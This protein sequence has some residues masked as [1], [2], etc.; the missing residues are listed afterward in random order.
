MKSENE[1]KAL[2]LEELQKFVIELRAVTTGD[3]FY[4]TA[5]VLLAFATGLKKYKEPELVEVT[6]EADH[7]V[8]VDGK[9][10][11]AGA[12]GKVYPWQA[13][14]L[15]RWLTPVGKV[16]SLL[17]FLLALA[18]TAGAQVQPYV[19]GGASQYNVVAVNGFYGPTNLNGPTF[20]NATG[21][22]TVYYTATVTNATA[23]YTNA[24]WAFNASGIWTNTPTYS[25]NNL[26]NQP[27]VVGLVNY[28]TA[29]IQF[30]GNLIAAGTG[31]NA[32][33]NW[34]FSN[35][36][37]NWQ[38]NALVQTLILNGTQFVT[39][40]SKLSLFGPGYIRLNSI[41]ISN[42][43]PFTNIL[44]TVSRKPSRTGP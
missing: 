5:K 9:E 37:V 38:T 19:L 18:F 30:G 29:N 8:P 16:A 1:I 25:T 35:D 41:S 10:I 20:T 24:N 22:G 4:P 14:A 39:T 7:P 26:I 12:T 40:N 15:S 42:G 34:D 33:A 17:V 28:D 6:N 2:P 21:G 11:A 23:I 13:A 32:L 44:V 36:A 3:K 27:G 43:V 31:T